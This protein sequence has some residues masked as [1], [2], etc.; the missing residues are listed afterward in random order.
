MPRM[1]LGEQ[2]LVGLFLQQAATE[3][4]HTTE[5]HSL[6]CLYPGPDFLLIGQ[7]S[8]LPVTSG[9]LDDTGPIRCLWSGPDLR[10]VFPNTRLHQTACA[11]ATHVQVR[12]E[13]R[14]L[15]GQGP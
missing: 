5:L 9:S 3:L 2:S 10:Q 11:I 1:T 15:S 4:S 14:G 13:G 8:N 12:Q 7:I 6:A